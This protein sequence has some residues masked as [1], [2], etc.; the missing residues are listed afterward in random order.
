MN[1]ELFLSLGITIL[2]SVTIFMYFRHRFKTMEHKVNTIFQLV[3][4]H[5]KSQENPQMRMHQSMGNRVVS[6][7]PLNIPPSPGQQKIEISDDEYTDTDCSD[8]D[9]ESNNVNVYKGV[10]NINL[11]EEVKQIS[12]T[13]ESGSQVP[14][15]LEEKK[16]L[17]EIGPLNDDESIEEDEE[18][19]E[20]KNPPHIVEETPDYAKMTVIELKKIAS[21][22]GITGYGKMRKQGLV[23]ILTN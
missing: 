1:R 23:D 6:G 19:D 11:D 18:D 7:S 8:S 5:A 2:T 15:N 22:K 3:Q 21:K 13:L 12:V 9:D 16:E 10:Q 20:E 4:N 17:D 14:I